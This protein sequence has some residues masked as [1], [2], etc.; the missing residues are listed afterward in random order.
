MSKGKNG[1][2]WI[3]RKTYNGHL[4]T[5]A[6]EPVSPTGPVF[7]ALEKNVCGKWARGAKKKEGDN[8]N[9]TKIRKYSLHYIR[10]CTYWEKPLRI[11]I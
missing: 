3:A 10:V 2:E 1:R 6:T 11:F 4:D 8:S 5:T 7:T 9:W